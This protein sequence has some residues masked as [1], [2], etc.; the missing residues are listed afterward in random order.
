MGV[1]TTLAVIA[2]ASAVYSADQ[3]RQAAKSQRRAL[4]AQQRQADIQNMRE[5]RAQ[6][7][8]GRVQAASIEAQAANSGLFGSSA[9]AGATANVQSRTGENISFL[10]QMGEL[11]HAASTANIQAAGYQSKAQLAEAIGQIAQSAGG[12]YGGT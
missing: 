12:I 2:A 10:D 4:Q 8:T 6:I 11:A 7:R 3:Q 9:A 1:M 5:R